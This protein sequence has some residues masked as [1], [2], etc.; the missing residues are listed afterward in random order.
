MEINNEN[1]YLF[2]NSYNWNILEDQW[3]LYKKNALEIYL[4]NGE[5]HRP[6][7]CFYQKLFVIIDCRVTFRPPYGSELE[8][9]LNKDNSQYFAQQNYVLLDQFTSVANGFPLRKWILSTSSKFHF[10][11]KIVILLEK[12]RCTTI[13]LHAHFAFPIK[14]LL[15]WMKNFPGP[16]SILPILSRQ[17]YEHQLNQSNIAKV[18]CVSTTDAAVLSFTFKTGDLFTTCLK[19]RI[20]FYWKMYFF[21]W[22]SFG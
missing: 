13:D 20:Q 15:P 6:L 19:K 5:N 21:L 18:K 3:I 22:T 4:S 10:P 2:G 7:S 17:P 1:G 16:P 12:I 9:Y 8:L 11:T 14:Y